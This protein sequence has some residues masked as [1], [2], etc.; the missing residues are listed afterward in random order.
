M[1]RSNL[2]DTQIW[3]NVKVHADLE[4]DPKQDHKEN[5]VLSQQR[6]MKE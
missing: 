3:E 4:L 1:T 5:P 6:E 2:R